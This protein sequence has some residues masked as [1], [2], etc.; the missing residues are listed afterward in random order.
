M[1]TTNTLHTP[2][3]MLPVPTWNA[4]WQKWQQTFETFANGV[5][6]SLFSLLEHVTLIPRVLPTVSITGG[7]FSQSGPAQFIS[8]TLQVEVGVGPN[9]LTLVPRALVCAH[10]QS[11][12][13][14]PQSIEWELRITNTEVDA[15]LV[16]FGVVGDDYSITWHN[17]SRLVPGTPMALFAFP[18]T[19]GGGDT[20]EGVTEMVSTART[21][22]PAEN[23]KW[24][25]TD[26]T[27]GVGPVIMTI[28]QAQ[29]VL[30]TDFGW[31]A[32]FAVG[33]NNSWNA[34]SAVVACT[35]DELSIGEAWNITSLTS[36]DLGARLVVRYS[37]AG[38]RRGRFRVVDGCGTW[39]D[40]LGGVH[41]LSGGSVEAAVYTWDQAV[42]GGTNEVGS[43]VTPLV[44]GIGYSLKVE[45]IA[46]T[47]PSGAD[48]ELADAA[49]SGSHEVMYQIGLTGGGIPRYE[50][51]LNPTWIDRN[52]FG[53]E[54]LTG[55]W[56]WRLTNLG[57]T[58]VTFRV[59]VRCHGTRS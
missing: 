49:F 23:R 45:C 50:P 41:N 28:D 44:D 51:S 4:D 31:Q 7:V 36:S 40:N 20:H 10:L 57:G 19:G 56:H 42:D 17:G 27:T 24:L 22:L 39:T 21:V 37:Y 48:L 11:G 32:T 29:F 46:G 33:H 43:V 5:D 12:A 34:V 52:P 2:R 54:G 14:G 47:A 55:A 13:V 18:G 15:D 30:G 35:T 53:F 9:P 16:V 26:G 58:T 8:R 25:E 3:F 1:T 6:S 38:S 59:T